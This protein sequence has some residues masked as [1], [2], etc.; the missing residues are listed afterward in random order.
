VTH[1]ELGAGMKSG[2]TRDYSLVGTT[3]DKW[4]GALASLSIVSFA[5][6]IPILPELQ[7]I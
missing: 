2:V 5:F 1:V 3:A 6:N 7:V 4:F